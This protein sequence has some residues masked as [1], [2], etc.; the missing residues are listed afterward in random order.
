M[1]LVVERPERGARRFLLDWRLRIYSVIKR[2]EIW[3]LATDLRAYI[4]EMMQAF[5]ESQLSELLWLGRNWVSSTGISAISYKGRLASLDQ[6]VHRMSAPMPTP[7]AT[8]LARQVCCTWLY[9]R[10]EKRLE[11]D[12]T[13]ASAVKCLESIRNRRTS[14]VLY[15]YQQA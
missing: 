4:G 1:T 2:G 7:P 10:P 11:A 13:E 12:S 8:S 3:S 14:S 5:R 6:T 15:S 9:H